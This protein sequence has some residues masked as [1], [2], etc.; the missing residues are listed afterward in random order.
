M[1]NKCLV[2]LK[3]TAVF[4]L[5]AFGFSISASAAAPGLYSIDIQYGVE[6]AVI[7][8]HLKADAKTRSAIIYVAE[9]TDA[10]Q[11]DDKKIIGHV[12]ERDDTRVPIFPKSVTQTKAVANGV[13]DI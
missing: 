1:K 6:Q 7:P 5:T 10:R 13:K 3:I 9:F 11:V 4:V 2:V 8:E 12:R